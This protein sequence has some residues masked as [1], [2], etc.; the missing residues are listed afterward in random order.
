MSQFPTLS[1]AASQFGFKT[2]TAMRRAF[3]RGILPEEFLLRVGA[4]TL[5]VDSER[6]AAWIRNQPAYSVKVSMK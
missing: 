5:R 3:E 4:R 1:E 6:L 2:G